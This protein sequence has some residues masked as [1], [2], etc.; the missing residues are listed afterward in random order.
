MFNNRTVFSRNE[1]AIA[2]E[3]HD[4]YK[5]MEPKRTTMMTFEAIHETMMLI[6]F[7]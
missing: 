6:I 3:I 1:K 7:C 4:S 2:H 5:L